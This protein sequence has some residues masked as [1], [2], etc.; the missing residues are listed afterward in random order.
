MVVSL[1][2]YSEVIRNN[3]MYFL[4]F[5]FRFYCRKSFQGYLQLLSELLSL[6]ESN[7]ELLSL[8]ESNSDL[9]HMCYICFLYL[10]RL[11]FR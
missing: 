8:D 9:G 4:V 2:P 11:C 10:K 7:S 1:P 3:K 6:D 5:S